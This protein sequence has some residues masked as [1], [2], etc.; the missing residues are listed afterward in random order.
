MPEACATAFPQLKGFARA[1]S[2]MTLSL[3][4][5]N[6]RFVRRDDE[7]DRLMPGRDGQRWRDAPVD[8]Q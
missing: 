5:R 8:E 2:A 7:L 1:R 4:A 3:A 6:L